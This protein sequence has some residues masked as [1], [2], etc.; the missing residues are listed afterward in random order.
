MNHMVDVGDT[1]PEAGI[2][3]EERRM[4][5]GREELRMVAGWGELRMV[6]EVGNHLAEEGIVVEARHKVVEVGSHL[7]VGI[8]VEEHRMAVE[9]IVH[10]EVVGNLQTRQLSFY[11]S[12][13]F[14]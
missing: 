14:K 7:A 1:R 3:V 8:A 12:A 11:R 13:S 9:D 6:A 4:V 2:V 5:A 10:R